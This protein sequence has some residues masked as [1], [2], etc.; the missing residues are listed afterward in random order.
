LTL[1]LLALAAVV[2]TALAGCS[3]GGADADANSKRTN[4][5]PVVPPIGPGTAR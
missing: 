4:Q 3:S 2:A 1:R 5:A